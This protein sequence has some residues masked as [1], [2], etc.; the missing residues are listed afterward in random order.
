MQRQIIK[1]WGLKE[2]SFFGLKEKRVLGKS[3]GGGG[4]KRE[5]KD[6]GP[7]KRRKT[8]V[9]K[10]LGSKSIWKKGQ[11]RGGGPREKSTT[12]GSRWSETY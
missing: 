7:P 11:G 10:K 8:C 1:N 4:E 6:L 2:P 5:G 9:G 3:L 12:Q